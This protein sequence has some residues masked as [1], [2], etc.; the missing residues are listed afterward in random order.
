MNRTTKFANR[1][2]A[3]ICLIIFLQAGVL[4]MVYMNAKIP[5]WTGQIIRLRTVPVDPRSLFRG[6]YALLRYDISRI[7]AKDVNRAGKPRRNQ[8]VYVSLVPEADGTYRYGGV[9]F[10]PP[11]DG[12]P[13]IRGRIKSPSFTRSGSYRVAY[14]IEAWFAPKQKAVAIE[15][16]LGKK[17]IA[18]IWL[19]EKGK[20][21][22]KGIQAD[23][24]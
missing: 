23:E 6:N 1:R 18:E 8:R 11:V 9:G 22:L 3:A 7:P 5:A 16:K 21:A 13:Y 17:G 14:G 15:K 12:A 19:T 20:A 24:N 2:T 10:E 4:A